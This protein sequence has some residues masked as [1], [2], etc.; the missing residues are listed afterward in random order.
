MIWGSSSLSVNWGAFKMEFFSVISPDDAKQVIADNWRCERKRILKPLTQCL[1]HILAAPIQAR[2]NVPGFAKSTVDGYAVQASSTFGA[3]ESLP[4]YLELVGQVEMGQEYRG[5]LAAGQGI[6]VP[7]GGMLPQDADAVVMFEQVEDVHQSMIAVLKAVAP[8]ENL[9]VAGEDVTAG[10][11]VLTA[12]RKLKPVDI[13]LLAAVGQLEVPVLEP[14]RVGIISTGDEVVSPD[15]PVAPGQIKDINSYTLASF[16]TAAG[17]EPTI[18]GIVPDEYDLLK[19]RIIKSVS[20][21]HITLVSGGSSVGTRDFTWRILEELGEPGIL[22]HGVSIKP[23]KPTLAAVAEDRLIFGL[24]GHPASALTAYNLL[25][26]E[27]IRWGQY[28]EQPI[29][30][31]RNKVT[32]VLT[33]GVASAPGRKDYIPVTIQQAGE[34]WKATPI[35]GKSGL[36]LPIIKSDGYMVIPLHKNGM[37]PGELVTITLW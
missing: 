6:K 22:F 9:I 11:E 36:I 10:A 27:L 35:L 32:A 24:P 14:I 15:Q 13:G 2:E 34:Q 30:E 17:G 28:L 18:Y 19:K 21:N 25:V 4:A 31:L 16:V 29:E 7:T 8:G 20:E 26:D 23:G 12:G 37:E 1:G 5:S 33:K 3:S